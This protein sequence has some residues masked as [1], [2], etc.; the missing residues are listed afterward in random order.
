M[1]YSVY[2]KTEAHVERCDVVHFKYPFVFLWNMYDPKLD[3]VPAVFAFVT[4]WRM[5]RYAAGSE[6]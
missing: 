4:A 1:H 2:V 6:H 3:A 5:R